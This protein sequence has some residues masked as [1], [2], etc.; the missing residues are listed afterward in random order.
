MAPP[1]SR[2]YDVAA[3]LLAAVVAEHGGTLPDRQFV[4]AGAP[5]W[6]CEL[7]AVWVESTGGHDG[8][9]VADVLQPQM[10]AA[11]HTMRY[12]TFVVELVRCTPAVPD[13]EGPTLGMPT[14]AQEDE[15]AQ[16]LYG[17]AQRVL[18]ALV[19]AE[20]DGALGGCHGLAFMGWQVLGPQGGLV[21]GQLRVRVNLSAGL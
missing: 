14:E 5:A 21:A 19:R 13:T 15:A 20:R 1:V 2:I 6:D 8:N 7:L 12:G 16:L 3:G 9:V 17:D 4:S 11:A 18:N 10:A